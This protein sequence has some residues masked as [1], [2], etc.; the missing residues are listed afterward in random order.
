MDYCKNAKLIGKGSQAEIYYYEGYAY[1]VFKENYPVEYINGEFYIQTEVNKT[2][3][4][5]IKYYK[6]DDEHVLKMD[7]INGITLV[8]KME[9]ANSFANELKEMI[10][11]QKQITN[12]KNLKLL[13]VKYCHLLNHIIV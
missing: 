9:K 10:D 13:Y 2:N 1:K 7:Y 4:K 3:L 11:I 6:T 5:T 12:I 8:E